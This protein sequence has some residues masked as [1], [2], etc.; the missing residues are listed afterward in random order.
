[1]EESEAQ[2]REDTADPSAPLPPG[3]SFRFINAYFD[4][5][6]GGD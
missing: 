3:V 2:R 5:N 1:M 4:P 6:A